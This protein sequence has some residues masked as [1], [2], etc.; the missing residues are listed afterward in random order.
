M[1]EELSKILDLLPL[2]NYEELATV[3]A[4]SAPT[5]S[6]PKIKCPRCGKYSEVIGK[7]DEHQPASG[8]VPV[9]VDRNEDYIMFDWHSGS[10]DIYIDVSCYCAHCNANLGSRADIQELYEENGED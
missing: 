9:V 1:S 6:R 3:Y 7:V 4:K 5:Y 8:V 2:L 10:A